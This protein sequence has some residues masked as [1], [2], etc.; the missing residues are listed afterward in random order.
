MRA[1]CDGDQSLYD[2]TLQ[3]ESRAACA[4][5]QWNLWKKN[6]KKIKKNF[7]KVA[8]EQVFKF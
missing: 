7:P 5:S 2:S 1:I 8:G 3:V 6:I 4:R